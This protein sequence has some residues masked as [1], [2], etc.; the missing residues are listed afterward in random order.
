MDFIKPTINTV[1][2]RHICLDF[3][4]LFSLNFFCFYVYLYTSYSFRLLFFLF[5]MI[6]FFQYFCIRSS[7]IYSYCFV[8]LFLILFIS[9]F[10]S[11]YFLFPLFQLMNAFDLC[12]HSIQFESASGEYLLHICEISMVTPMLLCFQI[13]I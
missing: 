12:S 4:L 9:L 8:Y 7:H 6:F 5:F 1:I 13:S 11:F 10:P 3:V 2:L